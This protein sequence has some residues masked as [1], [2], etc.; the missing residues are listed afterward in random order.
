MNPNIASPDQESQLL[1]LKDLTKRM[2]VLH[3]AQVLQ[4][5]MWPLTLFT[6]AKKTE[7][8]VNLETKEIDFDI[9]QT[10]GKK[11]TDLKER[12]EALDK[13]TRWLL[14]DDWVVRVRERGKVIFRKGRTVRS[15]E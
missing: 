10:K 15:Y 5:K 2:G 1:M 8:R 4:L 12:F 11:P 7:E 9:L 13:W 3:E 6:H 14:G